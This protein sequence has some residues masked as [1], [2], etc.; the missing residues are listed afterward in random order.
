MIGNLGNVPC[1]HLPSVK[2]GMPD[3]KPGTTGTIK[4]EPGTT[5]SYIHQAITTKVPEVHAVPGEIIG[6]AETRSCRWCG[7]TDMWRTSW[8][9]EEIWRCRQCHPPVDGAEDVSTRPQQNAQDAPQGPNAPP[10][11][12]E[13]GP[14]ICR[15]CS[16]TNWRQG[17]VARICADC[18]VPEKDQP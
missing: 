18:Q 14:F 6:K 1:I 11:M 7:S 5:K 8:P 12:V 10:D 17:I 3:G 15:A 2:P 16:S 4:T 9:H 13:Q